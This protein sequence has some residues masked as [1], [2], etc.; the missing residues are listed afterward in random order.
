MDLN[1]NFGFKRK[2]ASLLNL[3][4]APASGLSTH[5]GDKRIEES[6]RRPYSFAAPAPGMRQAVEIGVRHVG[7]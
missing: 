4:L 7:A 3:R 5:D 6:R 2:A 1:R